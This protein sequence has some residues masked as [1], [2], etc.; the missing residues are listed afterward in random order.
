MAAEDSMESPASWLHSSFRFSGRADTARPVSCGWP[1]N[2]GQS[3]FTG[4]CAAPRAAG[5][6]RTPNRNLRRVIQF[7][8]GEFNLVA[9]GIV[10]V[11]R[12]GD[13]MIF[14]VKR[15]T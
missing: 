12:M 1:R 8:S 11:N 13:L 4:G 6:M 2:C 15:N 7:V 5:E 3:S 14:E 9:V 10:E